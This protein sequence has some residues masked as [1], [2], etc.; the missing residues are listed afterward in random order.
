MKID[1]LSALAAD[2]ARNGSECD[3]PAELLAVTI[4]DLFRDAPGLPCEWS[5]NVNSD[6]RGKYIALVDDK[7]NVEEARGLAIALLRAADEAEA[8]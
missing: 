4:R 5:V 1:D 3:S 8:V 2:I 6:E 7:L